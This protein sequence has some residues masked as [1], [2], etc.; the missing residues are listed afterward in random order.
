MKRLLTV[1]CL[2]VFSLSPLLAQNKNVQRWEYFQVYSCNLNEL[3]KYGDEGWELAGVTRL[4]DNC[5][6]FTLKR[7]KPANAPKYVEPA[8]QKAPEAKVKPTC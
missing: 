8:K 4:P 2:L 5:S 7:P 3:N 1:I 6:T